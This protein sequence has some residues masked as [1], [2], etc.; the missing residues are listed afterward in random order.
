MEKLGTV[1]NLIR[2]GRL[3]RFPKRAE[4]R[5]I[6]EVTKDP[7]T[8]LKDLQE[9][10]GSLKVTVHDSTIRKTL[11]ENSIHGRVVRKTTANPEEY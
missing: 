11:G 9:S 6:Q 1:A 3:S 10:L 5:L 2:S 4:R 7:T 8:T